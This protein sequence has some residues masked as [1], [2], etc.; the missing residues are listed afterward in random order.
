MNVVITFLS[1]SH[2]IGFAALSVMAGAALLLGLMAAINPANASSEQIA[3]KQ[4]AVD[5]VAYINSQ[6]TGLVRDI[7]AGDNF[8]CA[9][10]SNGFAYCWGG[11]ENGQLGNNRRRESSVPVAVVNRN[12][13]INGQVSQISAG[14][15][16]TCAVTTAKLAYCWGFQNENGQLGN[17]STTTSLVPVLVV[18]GFQEDPSGALSGVAEVSSGGEHTCAIASDLGPSGTAYCWGEN[19]EGQLGRDPED[20]GLVG[21]AS[22]V[23]VK[24]REGPNG[25]KEREITQISAGSEAYSCAVNLTGSAYCWGSNA[26]GRLGANKSEE[27]LFRPQLVTPATGGGLKDVTQVTAGYRHSCAIAGSDGRAYC[28]GANRVGQ[29]GDNRVSGDSS[30]APVPVAGP[31]GNGLLS[32]VKQISVGDQ[33]TCAVTSS[34]VAYCWG[35]NLTGQLGSGANQNGRPQPTDSAVPIAVANNNGFVNGQ[36]AQ[37]SAGENHACSFTNSGTAY[38]WGFN[39]FGQLGD[40]SAGN[41]SSPIAV[42]GRVRVTPADVDFGKVDVRDSKSKDVAVRNFFPLTNQPIV[43]D[44]EEIEG[45]RKGFGFTPDSGCAKSAD[46]LTLVNGQVCEGAVKFAP[47][48]P[49]E[50]GGVVS[51]TPQAYPNAGTEFAA[52]GYA[53]PGANPGGAVVKAGSGDFGKVDVFTAKVENIKIRNTGDE[54]LKVTGFKIKND[55]D[56]EFAA[57]VK[58]CAKDQV[59]PGGSCTAKVQFF[60]RAEGESVALLDLKSNAIGSDTIA[61]F[62]EGV[63]PVQETDADG[64]PIGPNKVRKLTVPEKTLT[65]KEATARWKRPSGDVTV[66]EYQTRIKKK[67][68]NWKGWSN[69]DP[70]PNLK[71]W[72]NR[73]FKKLS[74]NTNYKVQVRALSYE[75]P[76]KKSAVNFTTDR[77]GIPTRPANG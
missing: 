10:T 8:S 77:N 2:R 12:G 48:T 54:P 16:H 32:S 6:G 52:S 18:T 28:W 1:A 51:L 65:A 44:I 43:T 25:F 27:L 36:A 30:P 22:R 15:E 39:N 53:A 7:S 73:T 34:G 76:G 50:F 68:G 20:K 38:C 3:L 9:V 71:G 33:Y 55:A 37:I 72:I 58:D 74:A 19:D 56:D 13:F 21:G 46:E 40:G 62:G 75:V 41:S 31:G 5:P 42:A 47:K 70:E 60:P 66:T 24:V 35:A 4:E 61:L 26:E 57:N 49:G 69:K 64:N 67:N 63:V 11:N 45:S 59:A 14:N 29:I 17:N 23:P